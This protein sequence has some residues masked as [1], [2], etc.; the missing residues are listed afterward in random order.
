MAITNYTDYYKSLSPEQQKTI[1]TLSRSDA[2]TEMDRLYSTPQTQ[3]I[4]NTNTY[5]APTYQQ[6][7]MGSNTLGMTNQDYLNMSNQS[8]SGMSGVGGNTAYSPTGFTQSGSGLASTPSN[9]SATYVKPTG[10]MNNTATSS[11][12]NPTANNTINDLSK[13]Q[14]GAVG[15]GADTVGTGETLGTGAGIDPDIMALI[16]GYQ[17]ELADSRARLAQV[18]QEYKS[19][20]GMRDIDAKYR[21]MEELFR[22][23]D[24]TTDPMYKQMADRT[25]SQMLQKYG[26]RGLGGADFAQGAMSKANLQLGMDFKGQAMKGLQ[27]QFNTLTGLEGTNYGRYRDSVG[28]VR[29]DFKTAQGMEQTGYNRAQDA[30]QQ[31]L[32]TYGFELNDTTRGLMDTFTNMTPEQR[33]Y[34]QQFEAN[35]AEEMG[36]HDPNS[37]EYN[38]LNA[39]RF[40]K[41]LQNFA[42]EPQTYGKYLMNDY[43]LNPMQVSTMARQQ[44]IDNLEIE[45]STMGQ[46]YNDFQQEI[47]NRMARNPNDPLIPY[48][49]IAR[50]EKIGAM[51]ESQMNQMEKMTKDA[52]DLWKITGVANDFVSQV[53]GIPL[54]AKT[55]DYYDKEGRLAISEFTAQTGRISANASAQNAALN[56]QKF[57]MQETTSKEAQL[58]LGR[59]LEAKTQN[60][61][62]TVGEF[63]ISVAGQ[64]YM[65]PVDGAEGPVGQNP[66][67]YT[68]SISQEELKE[69][70]GMLR[71]MG[72]FNV[73]DNVEDNAVEGAN[74]I[75]IDIQ[76]ISN[77]Q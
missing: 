40:N 17:K 26:S 37:P 74:P 67:N 34:S 36:N 6:S 51:N 76:K 52:M 44:G 72:Y 48:L 32:Q 21:E 16:A 18:P 23:Y 22:N 43:G 38:T 64:E 30:R 75:D 7:Q 62:I 24:P 65:R 14:T 1:G 3:P 69:F 53:L 47:N 10:N 49:Q 50:N 63:L 25:T 2:K 70:L 27:D 41:I 46:Y 60:P 13:M 42:S 33:Q 58:Y 11:N 45:K 57:E 12:F 77:Q 71:T 59:F 68:E 35:F 28:D 19:Q 15:A 9:P 66:Y 61:E 56:R 55:L 5:T 39:A 73:E 54:G 4:T 8:F 31:E 20:F 29:D